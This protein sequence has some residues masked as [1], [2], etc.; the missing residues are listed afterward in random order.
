ML[1]VV[2]ATSGE[3]ASLDA[4]VATLVC[5]VG[6][7]EGAASTA[8]SLAERRPGALLHVGLAGGRGIPAGTL[9][10]G[11]AALY[12]D[13]GAAVPV[14]ERVQPSSSLLAA[15]RRALPQARVLP[16][17]TSARVGGTR[18]ASVEAME[19]FAVLRAAELAGVPALEVRAIANEIDEPDRALWRFDEA[20]AALAGALP[21]LLAELGPL[22]RS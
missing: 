7:V 21:R 18:G 4:D 5:G 16:I 15:A 19:G 6:P 2:G 17:A 8:R 13:I 11:S 22:A 10:V 1:L 20:L 9:V 12:C 3:L 14:V